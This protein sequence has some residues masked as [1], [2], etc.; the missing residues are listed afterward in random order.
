MDPK[1]SIGRIVHFGTECDAAI[2]VH[3]WSETCINLAVFDHNGVGQTSRTSVVKAE[4][5]TTGAYS[6][7]WPERVG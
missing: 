5:E 3:V 7:H 1:P 2:V 6:W 4:G